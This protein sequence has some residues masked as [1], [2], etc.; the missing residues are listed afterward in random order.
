MGNCTDLLTFKVYQAES[1]QWSW[2]CY[3]DEGEPLAGGAGYA[4]AEEA[5]EAAYD[6]MHVLR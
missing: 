4:S 6:A 5:E 3:D 1:G 2:Q